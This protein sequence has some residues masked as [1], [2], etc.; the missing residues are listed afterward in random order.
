MAPIDKLIPE[1]GLM[2]L[3]SLGPADLHAAIQ[4]SPT[5]FRIFADKKHSVLWKLAQ[6]L[7]LPGAMKDAIGVVSCPRPDEG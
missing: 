3:E 2:L 5:L 7:I 1:L 4:A 6:T